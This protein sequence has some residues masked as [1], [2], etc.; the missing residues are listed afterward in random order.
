MTDGFFSKK[1]S[2]EEN[3]ISI[4]TT[5]TKTETQMNDIRATNGNGNPILLPTEVMIEG[6]FK[7]KHKASN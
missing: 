3:I 2:K 7:T 1:R 4:E 6:N 5:N